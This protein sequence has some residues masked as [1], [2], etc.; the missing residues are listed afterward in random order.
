[1]A[2]N[3]YTNPVFGVEIQAPA[4][5]ALFAGD[6]ASGYDVAFTDST[7]DVSSFGF[8]AVDLT[9][10]YVADENEYLQKQL[11][12]EKETGIDIAEIRQIELGG[13][14]VGAVVSKTDSDS[15]APSCTVVAIKVV[16][17]VP[18]GVVAT[19]SNEADAMAMLSTFVTRF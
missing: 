9:E 7:A 5:G 4:T 11:A 17:G 14:Q 12:Y 16:G 3:V 10:G 18:F 8:A 13:R 1:M 19:S 15:L 2:G 6:A